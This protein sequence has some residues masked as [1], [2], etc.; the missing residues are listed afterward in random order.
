MRVAM[1]SEVTRSSVTSR[2]FGCRCWLAALA[3]ISAC[4]LPLPIG[5]AAQQLQM[6]AAP[7]DTLLTTFYKDPRP[8]R[9]LGF[10]D[11]LRTMPAA[12]SWEAYPPVAGF[13]AITFR[14]FPNEIERL[15]PE[16]PDA[17]AA[18]TIA[19]ALRLSGNQAAQEK[20]QPRLA[21]SGRDLQ[22]AAVFANLPGK[23][24]DLQITTPSN[25]DILWGAAFASG[26]AKFVVMIIDYFARTANLD[27]EIARDIVRTVVAMAGGPREIFNE[28]RTRYGVLAA[29]QVVFASSALWAIQSNAR[30]HDFIERV[31]TTYIDQHPGTLAQK[32]LIATRPKGP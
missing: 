6:Q 26:D 7:G 28:L 12:Q 24:E 23:L 8:E 18:E 10:F 13:F 27:E 30:Q 2:L 31:V 32:A 14:T 25:L 20:F 4:A 5:A 9:L 17:Q 21:K 29:R 22:L 16:A 11:Q 1:R 3:A 19:A 15:I